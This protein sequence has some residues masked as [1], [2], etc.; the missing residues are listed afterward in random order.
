M[1]TRKTPQIDNGVVLLSLDTLLIGSIEFSLCGDQPSGRPKSVSVG[2][3]SPFS[4][5]SVL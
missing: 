2:G 5:D 1:Q 4:L 3:V